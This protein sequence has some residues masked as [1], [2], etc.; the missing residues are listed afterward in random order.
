MLPSLVCSLCSS[1]WSALSTVKEHEDG[2]DVSGFECTG[3]DSVDFVGLCLCGLVQDEGVLVLGGVTGGL[4]A[5][6]EGA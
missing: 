6:V 3:R 2:W 1:P 5:G 4:G